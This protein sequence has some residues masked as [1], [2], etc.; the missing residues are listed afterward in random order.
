MEEKSP[1]LTLFWRLAQFLLFTFPLARMG[2]CQTP[3]YYQVQ[4]TACGT[5]Y[6]IGA[7]IKACLSSGMIPTA[8]DG[9]Q[10]GTILLPNTSVPLTKG[11]SPPNW[12]WATPVVLGPGV[13]LVG[14]GLLASYFECTV[15]AGDCL[16]YDATQT[17]GAYT[18]TSNP[19]SVWQGFTLT[20]YTPLGWSEPGYK[21]T[22]Y[23]LNL[24]HFKDAR[25]LTVRDVAAD[26]ATGACF[27]FENV[28]HWTERNLFENVS[29]MYNCP[30]GW[31]F[32]TSSSYNSFGY[33]RFLDIRLNLYGSQT[34]FS[35][36]NNGNLYNSTLR[37]TINKCSTSSGTATKVIHMQDTAQITSS[38]LHVYAEDSCG[39]VP[40]GNFLD[41]TSSSNVLTYFGEV[42]PFPY[43]DQNNNIARGAVVK[44]GQDVSS[45]PK[46]Q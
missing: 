40:G 3:N 24:F 27:L 10:V 13:S 8:H 22:I 14:Q 18:R 34:G 38:E 30:I 15:S 41:I 45:L 20:G 44:A 6:D 4:A 46:S 17:S 12:V 1:L 25:G 32:K 23:P 2:Q 26:G 9:L 37:A 33:N 16:T 39:S 35:F 5:G 36:E 29:S 19:A 43:T 28:N 7:L 21:G 31:R 42:N 11:G